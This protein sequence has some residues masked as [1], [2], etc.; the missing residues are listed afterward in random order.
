MFEQHEYNCASANARLTPIPNQ[1][2]NYGLIKISVQFYQG[3]RGLGMLNYRGFTEQ[4]Y[5]LVYIYVYKFT[6]TSY[7]RVEC[8]RSTNWHSV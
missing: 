6:L 1:S 8:K 7:T 5:A 2:Y 4:I 3:H